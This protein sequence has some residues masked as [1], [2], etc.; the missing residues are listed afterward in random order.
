M[1]ENIKKIMK[2]EN[3]LTNLLE[4]GIDPTNEKCDKVIS[5][6]SN[7]LQKL[8]NDELIY[9]LLNVE[10]IHRF[11]NVTAY[12]KKYKIN[13]KK[14]KEENSYKETFKKLGVFV[15]RI[16]ETSISE[17][18]YMYICNK[19]DVDNVA[20]YLLTNMSNEDIMALSWESDDWNYKLFLFENLKK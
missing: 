5:S 17:E 18:E 2:L 16:R 15:E 9:V 11:I 6:I 7:L 8:S 4:E 3:E 14:I 12:F 20:S 1:S 10:F 19:C 13:K